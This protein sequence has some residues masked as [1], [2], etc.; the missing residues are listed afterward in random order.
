MSRSIALSL[1]TAST[2]GLGLFATAPAAHAISLVPSAEGELALTNLPCL[3]NPCLTPPGYSITSLSLLNGAGNVDPQFGLSRLFVD[4][5]GTANKYNKG[6]VFLSQ[7]EGTNGSKGEYWLRPV[8][9]SSA[10]SKGKGAVL[11]NG[12]LE[13]GRFL[14]NFDI[15]WGEVKLNFLDVEDPGKSGVTGYYD[16]KGV[17]HA[18]SS[19]LPGTGNNK[20]LS[21][22]LTDVK[23]L[24]VQ[25]GNPSRQYGYVS[26]F[27][28]NGDGVNLQ[29]EV[30]K[31]V[32]V[33]EPGT[34]L[35]LGVMAGVSALGLRQRKSNPAR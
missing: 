18:I 22:L 28:T 11:E 3:N 13:V 16:S 32:G 25:L 17:Y 9:Y 34:L 4:K 19:L 6:I 5:R 8:A 20:V 31:P 35:G 7:D 30:S 21:L 12:R 24:E 29:I 2:L 15:A 26:K 1:L 33:P 10:T 27:K 14:F 23:S